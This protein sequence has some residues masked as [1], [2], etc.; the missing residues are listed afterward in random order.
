MSSAQTSVGLQRLCGLAGIVFA[1]LFVAGT[2]LADPP[3][4]QWAAERVAQFVSEHRTAIRLEVT[5]QAVSIFFLLWFLGGLLSGPA[6]TR[7]APRQVTAVAIG[8]AIC[9][10]TVIIV[11]ILFVGVAAFQPDH[12]PDTTKTLYDLGYL[13][14]PAGV[15]ALVALF[16]ALGLMTYYSDE[17][18]NWLAWLAFAVCV[19]CAVQIIALHQR[20]GVFSANQFAGSYLGFGLA[21]VWMVV[22]AVLM[23]RR[24]EAGK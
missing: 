17:M 12:N 22:A 18:P 8:S 23:T 21:L 19:T 5:L 14:I 11:S 1:V 10:T 13:A 7:S 16:S 24:Q 20:D 6:L 4:Q 15:F 3:G 9:T 2:A